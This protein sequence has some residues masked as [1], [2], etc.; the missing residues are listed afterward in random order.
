MPQ[1]YID[2]T[3][4][5]PTKM[6]K[7][8]KKITADN[9]TDWGEGHFVVWVSNYPSYL[10]FAEEESFKKLLLNSE[11]IEEVRETDKLFETNS[12]SFA[13]LS[14]LYRKIKKSR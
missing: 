11:F 7:W 4:S 13:N 9:E 8:G 10:D 2:P 5:E 14:E 6:P 1:G 3:F 12:T